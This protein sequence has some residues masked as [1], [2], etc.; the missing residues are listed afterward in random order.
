MEGGE[1]EDSL[2]FVARYGGTSGPSALLTGDAESDVVEG[3]LAAGAVG[4]VDLLK[5]GHHGSAAS[6]TPRMMEALDP[7]VAV[8]SAGE[9]NRYG[10][11]APECVEAVRSSG[12]EFLCTMDCGDVEFRPMGAG[13]EV[14][15][16]RGAGA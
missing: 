11:P 5:V 4:E 7:D 8:A 3:L 6:T 12:A 9:G 1:N 10:H 16:A 2:V 15:C 13:F 14:R